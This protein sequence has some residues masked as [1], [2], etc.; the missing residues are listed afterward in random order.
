MTM[1]LID[2]DAN[3]RPK[4]LDDKTGQY[5]TGPRL[6]LDETLVFVQD[7]YTLLRTTSAPTPHHY[8]IHFAVQAMCRHMGWLP[9]EIAA[10]Q[11]YITLM[12]ASGTA[13]T[14]G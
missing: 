13:A 11:Q 4:L 7:A 1:N 6:T 14:A 8:T 5:L 9:Y 12:N 10:A 2:A 3:Q